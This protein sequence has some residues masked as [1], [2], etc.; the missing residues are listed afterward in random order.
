MT[1]ENIIALFHD[2]KPV[3]YTLE[4]I[5][6]DAIDSRWV[7]TVECENEK[8]MLKIASNSFTT[9][10]R[11]SG[12]ARMIDEFT[13]LG[14]YSPAI[15]ESL[16][17]KC[18]ERVTYEGINC[19]VWE[20][21]FEKFNLHDNMDKSVH[22]AADGK[23]VYHDEVLGFLAKVGQMHYDFF[24]YPSAWVRFE[25]FSPDD[26][27][28]EITECVE[29]FNGLV[30]EK[31][32]EFSEQWNRILTLFEENQK[33]LEAIYGE[34][35]TSVFQ[36]DEA[37]SN[38]I[39]DDA[40]HFVGVIDYNIAGKEVVINRFLTAVLYGLSDHRKWEP[41]GQGLPGLN[42]ETLESLLCIIRDAFGTLREHYRFTETEV[43]AL[44]LLFKYIYPIE[45]TQI[46]ALGKYAEEPEKLQM[47]FDYIEYVL[48]KED[49]D[50]RD[51]MLP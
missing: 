41:D 39:L 15:R 17:G 37:G 23:H 18:V 7:V 44:P 25:P 40:G 42:E 32:P 28:D 38:L 46:D 48:R 9:E 3:N 10:E 19:V 11:I 30:K 50:L 24:T 34:L 43:I 4:T 45:Y 33:K 29:T 35:P 16:N 47:L 51:A 49:I 36:A 6:T 8:Y 12:W 20:E 13:K 21:K 26:E 27:T 14:Y 1:I 5:R 22:T 2:E 31:A